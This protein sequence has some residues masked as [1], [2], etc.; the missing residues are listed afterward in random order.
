VGAWLVARDISQ[1]AEP[2]VTPIRLYSLCIYYGEDTPPATTLMSD[3][4][5]RHL[6]CPVQSA[7]RRRQGHPA[8]GVSDQS[9]D[10]QCARAR[11]AHSTHHP[12]YKKLPLHAED[13]EISVVR[14]Q[15]DCPSSKHLWLQ[16]LYS[17]CPWA[18]LSGPSTFVHAPLQL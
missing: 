8:D 1:W 14:A 12:F 10:E 5:S 13:T 18:H 3:A 16:A 9:V 6:M 7:G 2:D 15:E 11:A 4:P 17:L